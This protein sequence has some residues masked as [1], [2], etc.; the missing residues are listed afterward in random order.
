M[1]IADVLQ[2]NLIPGNNVRYS[3]ILPSNVHKTLFWLHGYQ[4]RSDQLLQY[5]EFM[6]LA[7][8]HHIAVIFP[9]TPDTYYIDQKWSH[10][11]TEKFLIS[12]FIPHVTEK[13]QLPAGRNQTFL[14]GI[15]MGGF[16]S[17]LIGSHYPNYF[18]KIAC[19][20]G[21]FIID[22]LLIGNP[23]ITGSISN[24]IHFQN[25]FGDI[26]SLAKD[27]S[28]N[29]CLAAQYSVTTDQLS[30][31][32]LTCGTNDLLY[33][34]NKKLYHQLLSLGADVTWAETPG[35]HDNRFFAPAINRVFN[36]LVS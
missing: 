12:E 31:V 15:S 18:C 16:G 5:K 13:Y 23:E 30:P 28:R 1:I 8:Q 7:E 11:Y 3:M 20:S 10:C 33:T 22:D 17:L 14:A 6:Q 24:I 21:A 35:N 34:R 36:W 19:I 25:L 32:Y 27:H 26:P 4:E 2:T 29:P 9:D